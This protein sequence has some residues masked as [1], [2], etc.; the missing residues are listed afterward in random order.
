MGIVGGGLCG[1]LVGLVELGLW[2]DVV[3]VVMMAL[4]RV[5]RG[6]GEVPEISD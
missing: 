3:R 1:G 2:S 6:D 4:V 5:L